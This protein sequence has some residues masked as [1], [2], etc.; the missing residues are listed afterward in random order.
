MVYATAWR[1]V[2]SWIAGLN[3]ASGQSSAEQRLKASSVNVY[4]GALTV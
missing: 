4:V 1:I 3:F 2:L